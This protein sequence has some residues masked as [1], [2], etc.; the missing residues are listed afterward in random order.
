MK[1]G[2]HPE[3]GPVTFQCACGN[4]IQTRSTAQGV[5]QV[6]LCAACHPFFSGKQKFIDTAGR[7]DRFKKK[8]GTN[9]T[10]T[11]KKPKKAP[12]PK[13]V[14]PQAAPEEKK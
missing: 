8:F 4:A 1:K 14:A 10:G 3:Y 2:I 9:I 7:I 13:P 6:D 12:E 5:V 11:I